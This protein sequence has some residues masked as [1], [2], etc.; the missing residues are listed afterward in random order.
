MIRIA[1]ATPA[2]VPLLHRL[3]QALSVYEK[4]QHTLVATEADLERALF[5]PRPCAEALVASL[6]EQPVGYA[7]FFPTY[8]TFLG[9]PGLW[10]ED[11]FVLPEARG[12]G[13]GRALL[14]RLAVLALERGGGRLEWAVLDWNEPSIAFYKSLG[15]VPLDDWTT[16]RVA[17]EA[18]TTLATVPAAR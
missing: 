6:E 4:L 5:G 11:L 9:K 8:S 7:L 15:A 17:G 13:V 3:V 18:L 1:A 14:A 2:D 12:R 10:L 16:Y